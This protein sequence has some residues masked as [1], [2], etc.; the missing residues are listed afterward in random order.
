LKFSIA[1]VGL[2]AVLAGCGGGGTGSSSSGSGSGSG[3]SSSCP[4]GGTTSGTAAQTVTINADPN[5][6]GRYDPK[7]INAKVGDT[8]E[9]TWADTA[10]PHTVTANDGTFDSCTQ[11]AGYKFF[12]TVNKAG[13]IQYHCTLHSGMVGDIKVS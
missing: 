13:D 1:A 10:S 9:W 6:I 7:T 4:K 5:T 2:A 3:S 11:N 12:V 8:I